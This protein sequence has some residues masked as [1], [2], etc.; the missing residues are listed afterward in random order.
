MA[1]PT[2]FVIFGG[3]GDLTWRKLVPALYN[4]WL[5]GALPESFKV[6]AL[7]MK[8]MAP[9]AFVEHL[10]EGVDRFSRRGKSEEEPWERFAG[11]ISY[12]RAD[13]AEG[14][15]FAALAD[16]LAD[17]EKRWGQPA[18]RVFYL[19]VPPAAMQVIASQLHQS[20]FAADAPRVRAVFEKPFGHDLA[21][22]RELNVF[23]ADLFQESQIYRID[24]YLGKEPVQN[25]LALRFANSVHEPLWNRRYIDSVQITVAE[26]EGVGT[27]G[28]Y[29]ERAGALRDMVQNH[30]M[31]VLCL[32]AMEPPVTFEADE[33]RN[34]KL[35]VLRAIRRLK[36]EE[37]HQLAER[38]QYGPGLIAGRKVAGY[39]S[40]PGVDP[41]STTETFVALKLFVDNWRW[42]DVPFY[43]RTGKRL[44][45]RASE[46]CI[47]FRPVPHQAF[48]PS[49]IGEMEP[50]RLLLRIQP[51]EEIV[52]RFQAKR[53]G[54]DMRLARVE[55]RFCY[56]EAFD[57]PEP[58]AYETLLQD[59]IEGDPSQFMRRDQVEEAWEVV[60]PVLEYW[61]EQGPSDLP[62]YP[63]GTW[64][65]EAAH[66]LA[67]RDGRVWVEPSGLEEEAS[68][69]AEAPG[70][71]IRS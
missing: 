62:V 48:P 42:Q 24:H 71:A 23:L 28:G 11:N 36:P 41:H 59:I 45:V 51:R 46:V 16:E 14:A 20:G 27:R 10:R 66:F 7:D 8:D 56:K 68:P 53:P 67:A 70:G 21:T 13:F 34:K 31:Q 37:V 12:R 26:Q 52:M 1:N 29:Y 44:P 38:G 22:A 47:Q 69:G 9:A 40:E 64:G 35:D 19:A 50:N 18:I 39:R 55:T 2:V 43:L 49:A 33:L 4:L 60:M 61:Q 30:L 63:A 65:P 3:G 15:A 6:I 54:P 17:L 57:T 25:I 5:D 32:V 58:E